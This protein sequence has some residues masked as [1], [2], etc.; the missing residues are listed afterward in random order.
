MDALEGQATDMQR[1]T[2]CL[3]N[4]GNAFFPPKWQNIC[5]AEMCYV[6]FSFRKC[7]AIDRHSHANVRQL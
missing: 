6:I 3:G 4:R 5:K 1:F 2:F 7:H